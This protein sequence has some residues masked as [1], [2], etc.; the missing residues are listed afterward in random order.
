MAAGA[1]AV[2]RMTAI[3]DTNATLLLNALASVGD[4]EAGAGVRAGRE[5]LQAH[6]ERRAQV[7]AEWLAQ[8][9]N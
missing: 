7:A 4:E 5:E 9:S 3:Y 2:E 6:L 1:F 8:N